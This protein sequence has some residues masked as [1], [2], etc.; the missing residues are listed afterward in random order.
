MSKIWNIQCIELNHVEEDLYSTKVFASRFNINGDSY[1]M[2]FGESYDMNGY[3]YII[4]K[5]FAIEEE[6]Q[7]LFYD[8]D[9]SF[10]TKN[11]EHISF[12]EEFIQKTYRKELT[13]ET[14][15]FFSK[16]SEK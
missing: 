4:Y 16:R 10:I 8:N 5:I 3:D 12:F 1:L 7:T 15:P 11:I 14:F 13:P 6:E 2:I 9:Y